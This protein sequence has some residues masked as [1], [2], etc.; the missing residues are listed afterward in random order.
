MELLS[1]MLSLAKKFIIERWM[2][3]LFFFK[4]CSLSQFEWEAKIYCGGFSPKKEFLRS[5]NSSKPCLLQ[6]EAVSLGRVCG[7]PSLPQGLRFLCGRQ[8]LEK[9]L[10]WII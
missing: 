8:C 9:F 7:G 5:K 3:L 2:S 10:L 1:E 4:N 6:K